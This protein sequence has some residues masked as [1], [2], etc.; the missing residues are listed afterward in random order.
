MTWT[1]SGDPA[2]NDRDHVRF[3]IQDTNALAQLVQDEEIAFAIS[4]E[5]GVTGAAALVLET[6]ARRYAQQADVSLTSGPDTVKRSNSQLAAAFADRA[7]EL[8]AQAAAN[9]GAPWYGGGSQAAKD[10]RRTEP[11]RVQPAFRRG[12]FDLPG[13]C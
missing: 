9:T 5:G 10:A 12:E 4:Q 13:A 7:R 1:Y 8:R 3:L 6:L 2:A 11:D